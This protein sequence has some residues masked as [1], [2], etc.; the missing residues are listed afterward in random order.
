MPLSIDNSSLA[1]PKVMGYLSYSM[2][3]GWPTIEGEVVQG[4]INWVSFYHSSNDVKS[5]IGEVDVIYVLVYL[6]CRI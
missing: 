3:S 1:L 2:E 5:L 4:A 6:M